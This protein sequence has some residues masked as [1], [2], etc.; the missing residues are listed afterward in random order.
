MNKLLTMKR[1]YRYIGLLLI[2]AVVGLP[3]CGISAADQ[4]SSQAPAAAPAPG[5]Y[6]DLKTVS[7]A[8]R[9]VRIR[10]AAEEKDKEAISAL[11]DLIKTE[12]ETSVRM[13]AYRALGAIGE[14]GK[15]NEV[16]ALLAEKVKTESEPVL[17]YS[18]VVAILALSGDDNIKTV[19]EAVEHANKFP[20]D[21]N[22]KDLTDK[23][24][25]AAKKK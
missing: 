8:D 18:A 10:K 24:I 4:T 17:Q 16:T 5:K 7:S 12:K 11:M 19:A 20:A 9:I 23:V 13:N 25:A 14:K 21:A 2:A 3:F 15:E 1:N 22:V 6:A